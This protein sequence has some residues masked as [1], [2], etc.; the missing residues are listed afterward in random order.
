MSYNYNYT[1]GQK[2]TC[3][4]AGTKDL[5]FWVGGTLFLRSQ[6]ACSHTAFADCMK[7]DGNVE[8]TWV[9]REREM[10]V[11]CFCEWEQWAIYSNGSWGC[12]LQMQDMPGSCQGQGQGARQAGRKGGSENQ[13]LHCRCMYSVR[14]YQGMDYAYPCLHYGIYH[15]LQS[16]V[17]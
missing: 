6:C 1:T 10:K 8:K 3:V 16:A 12:S 9:C 15:W 14:W 2:C 4:F 7:R 17:C 11:L 13:S 5:Q